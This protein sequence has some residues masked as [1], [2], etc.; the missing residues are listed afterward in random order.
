MRTWSRR[1]RSSW[2]YPLMTW[3][4]VGTFPL[5]RLEVRKGTIASFMEW[6]RDIKWSWPSVGIGSACVSNGINML[7]KRS[8]GL[9]IGKKH[10]T[11]TRAPSPS[12]VTW[13]AKLGHHG[14]WVEVHPWDIAGRY[15]R[16]YPSS[17]RTRM[18][19]QE[20]KS[21]KKEFLGTQNQM[22]KK[23][24]YIHHP[25]AFRSWKA[26]SKEKQHLQLNKRDQGSQKRQEAKDAA[27]HGRD[28]PGR[29]SQ[30][31]MWFQMDTHKSIQE[32]EQEQ[33]AVSGQPRRVRL[34]DVTRIKCS[35]IVPG[36]QVGSP[37]LKLRV[38]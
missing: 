35:R 19:L 18:M 14:Q 1:A 23:L 38:T 12:I 36:G 31:L 32:R 16:K 9:P 34:P 21:L 5:W 7:P 10:K 20:K 29:T 33:T 25:K 6:I 4:L 17:I 28:Y 22:T 26:P 13:E 24:Q 27:R 11:E 37:P 8:E 30:S 3:R 2:F 15:L